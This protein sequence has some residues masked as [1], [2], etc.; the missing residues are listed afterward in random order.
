[1]KHSR[2][3]SFDRISEHL[4]VRQKYSATRRIFTNRLGVWECGQTRSV[5]Y[6]ILPTYSLQCLHAYLH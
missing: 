2:Q 4:E 3:P 1:M 5:V 6:D